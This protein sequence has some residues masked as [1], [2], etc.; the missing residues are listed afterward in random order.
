M[1]IDWIKI[2]D[3]RPTLNEVR[4][5]RNWKFL[6]SHETDN[7]TDAAYYATNGKW[8]S[9]NCEIFPTHWAELPEPVKQI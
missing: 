4:K 2:T 3:R 7:W 6:V 8:T 5:D 9:D 1:E